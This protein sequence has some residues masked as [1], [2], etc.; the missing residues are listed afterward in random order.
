MM[1]RVTLENGINVKAELEKRVASRD[2]RQG[3]QND[4]L[5]KGVKKILEHESGIFIP[6][7]S[8]KL[9]QRLG[10]VA[11]QDFLAVQHLDQCWNALPTSSLLDP[12]VFLIRTRRF[13]W[14]SFVSI[15]CLKHTTWQT[16]LMKCT[17]DTTLS[18]TCTIP[19]FMMCNT[20]FDR[21]WYHFYTMYDFKCLGQVCFRIQIGFLPWYRKLMFSL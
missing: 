3:I 19:I 18:C 14:F 17:N 1:L 8:W 10:I 2:K 4:W 20:T 9:K 11:A 16:I 15:S 13:S 7:N 5:E 21:V 6:Q 12:S